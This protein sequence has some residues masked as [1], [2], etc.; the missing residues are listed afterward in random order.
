MPWIDSTKPHAPE[1]HI[2]NNQKEHSMTAWL[3]KGDPLD[4]L[5]GFAIYQS[6]SATLPVATS[7]AYR[8]I[9]YDP[10]AEFTILNTEAGDKG[11][12]HYYFV[13]AVSRTNVESDPVPVI[14]SN[15]AR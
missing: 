10:V 9:P 5:R 7:P 12:P 3:S 4:T 15:F 14:F 8:F 2:E 11:L 6:D 13:T 1:F